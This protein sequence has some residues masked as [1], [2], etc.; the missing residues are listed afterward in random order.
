M[1]NKLFLVIMP[2]Q[3]HPAKRDKRLWGRKFKSSL[4]RGTSGSGDKSEPNW[5]KLV[6]RSSPESKGFLDF[7]ASG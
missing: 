1:R 6:P 3:A 7:L 5:G 4:Q 2:D